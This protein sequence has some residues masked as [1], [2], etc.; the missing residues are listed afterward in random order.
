MTD[1]PTGVRVEFAQ[2]AR[3]DAALAHMRCHLA[4][5]RARG[6]QTASS[7]PLYMKGIEIRLGLEPRTVEIVGSDAKVAHEI[8]K[9]SREE[10]ILVEGERQ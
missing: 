5:A 4:F 8:Q 6:F 7:C 2:G 1:I 9:R 10:A 3:V